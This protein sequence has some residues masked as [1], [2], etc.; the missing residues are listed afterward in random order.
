VLLS[1]SHGATTADT[2]TGN[3]KQ[4]LSGGGNDTF[5]FA[6]GS[7]QNKITD[8]LPSVSGRGD[9][10]VDPTALPLNANLGPGGSF[11]DTDASAVVHLDGM[12]GVLHGISQ[13]SEYLLF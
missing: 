9:S 1:S 3:V 4:L 11:S 2:L 10:Y 5:V 13:G 8:L 12:G 7:G 6:S